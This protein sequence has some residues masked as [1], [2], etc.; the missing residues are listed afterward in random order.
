MPMV[1]WYAV[2]NVSY[3]NLRDATGP[4]MP[5]AQARGLGTQTPG[6]DTTGSSPAREAVCLPVGGAS[7]I[8]VMPASPPVR[9]FA[10]P[11]S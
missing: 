4:A 8:V 7:S 2:S 3:M 10:C 1:D 6:C 11:A 9:C 5:I